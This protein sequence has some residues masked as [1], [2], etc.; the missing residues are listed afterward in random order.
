MRSGG[1]PSFSLTIWAK[2]VSLPCPIDVE[3]VNRDTEPS[4]L[5]LS[6][7]VSGFIAVYGPPATSIGL[8]MPRPRSLPRCR[9]S[10]RR[11]SKPA[12]SARLNAMSIP[13]PNSPQ[14]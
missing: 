6:S 13:R 7:A 5:T 1:T 12:R 4:A 2:A 3:P 9:A 11:F 8:A 10:A 14:S